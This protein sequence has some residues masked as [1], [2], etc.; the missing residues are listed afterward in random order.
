MAYNA[1]NEERKELVMVE[2][3]VSGN[4]IKAAQITN[5]N[6]GNVS[7]DI[8]TFYTDKE[9]NICPTSKGVRFSADSLLD[10][11]KGLA[12]AL[13]VDE[14]ELLIDFLNA[15]LGDADDAEDAE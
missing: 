11:M 2:K 14:K 3:G 15:S 10:I 8:R 7:I 1:N 9:G 12:D 5:K 13:E 4:C 6:S